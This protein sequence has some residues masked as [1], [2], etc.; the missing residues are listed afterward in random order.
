MLSHLLI[1]EAVLGTHRVDL[2]RH[3]TFSVWLK[4]RK[5]RFYALF[6]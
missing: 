3:A 2:H 1:G 4:N 6:H 5:E